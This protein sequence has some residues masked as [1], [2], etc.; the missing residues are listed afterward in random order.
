MVL[1]L[2]VS[3][4]LPIILDLCHQW[5]E[6][7][8]AS[9]EYR[10][11]ADRCVRENKGHRLFLLFCRQNLEWDIQYTWSENYLAIWN[12]LTHLQH[13]LQF[14]P[15]L[16][17]SRTLTNICNRITATIPSDNNP[18][19]TLAAALKKDK[20]V[21]CCRFGANHLAQDGAS[22]LLWLRWAIVAYHLV[23]TTK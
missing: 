4:E 21:L 20:L 17:L 5:R 1:L 8:Q 19:S 13:H 3:C 11:D 14:D 2:L 10:I 15:E 7:I 6:Q 18:I 9:C 22:Y 12:I 16:T 23:K